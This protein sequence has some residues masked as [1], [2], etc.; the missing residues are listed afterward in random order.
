MKMKSEKMTPLEFVV[1]SVETSLARNKEQSLQL[2]SGDRVLHF[3]WTIVRPTTSVQISVVVNFF[4]PKKEQIIVGTI[5]SLMD[6]Y[7][8]LFKTNSALN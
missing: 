6:K 3:Y 2:A 1:C 7:Y 8:N 5:I 4:L